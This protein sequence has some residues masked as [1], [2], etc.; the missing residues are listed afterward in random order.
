M[1]RWKYG[2]I[3]G[4]TDWD[5][6]VGLKPHYTAIVALGAARGDIAY[7]VRW[8]TDIDY[9]AAI[10][11]SGIFRHFSRLCA[12]D[13]VD[14]WDRPPSVE[15]Y[16]RTGK[17]CFR[18]SAARAC[19]REPSGLLL[20]TPKFARLA[21]RR[22]VC[23]TLLPNGKP[24]YS[25]SDAFDASVFSRACNQTITRGAHGKRLHRLLMEELRGVSCASAA[26]P[27]SAGS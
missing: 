24:Y 10:N 1:S 27:A 18:A 5:A 16:L 19:L 12:L 22:A 3:F 9:L 7:R 2:W 25:C 23:P 14:L 8:K 13:V 11:A 21:A 20:R 6:V 17:D 4:P 26:L 15:K